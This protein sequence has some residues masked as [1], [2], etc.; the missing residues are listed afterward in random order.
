MAG[1][2]RRETS[3]ATS[4]SGAPERDETLC[5]GKIF[6]AAP[7]LFLGRLCRHNRRGLAGCIHTSPTTCPSAC[8]PAQAD[9]TSFHR[10][11]RTFETCITSCSSRG[12]EIG[13][14]ISKCLDLWVS[15]LPPSSLFPTPRK[16]DRLRPVIEDPC[17]SSGFCGCTARR[18]VLIGFPPAAQQHLEC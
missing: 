14:I 9:A 4:F 8:T 13:D 2:G 18:A 15:L 7:F 10:R 3:L 6:F 1:N 16:H 17:D 5:G 11:E 12:N